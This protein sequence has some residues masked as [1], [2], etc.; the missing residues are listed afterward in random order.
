MIRSSQTQCHSL[1]YPAPSH[2][3][4]RVPGCTD[5]NHELRQ[6]KEAHLVVGSTIRALNHTIPLKEDKSRTSCRFARICAS[7]I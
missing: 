4:L 6:Y 5:A 7:P 3:Y 2:G 1:H